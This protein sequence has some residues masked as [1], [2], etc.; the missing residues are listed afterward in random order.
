MFITTQ[1]LIL[2]ASCFFLLAPCAANDKFT[3]KCGDGS[4]MMM[5]ALRDVHSENSSFSLKRSGVAH[6]VL[7]VSTVDMQKNDEKSGLFAP[8]RLLERQPQSSNYCLIAAGNRIEALLSFEYAGPR[9]KYG[10]PGSGHQRCSDGHDVMDAIDVRLWANKELGESFTLHLNSEIGD[11][12]FTYLMSNDRHWI[13][14]DQ[15][16]KTISEVCYYARGEEVTI[17]YNIS[18][19]AK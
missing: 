19:P 6:Y 16:K 3:Q 13:L 17:R 18:M 11:K 10:I 9:K 2:L 4:E 7:I 12:N 15:S 14:L 1:K 5:Y 8:W